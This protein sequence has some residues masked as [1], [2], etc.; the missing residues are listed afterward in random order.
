MASSAVERESRIASIASSA[1]PELSAST[2]SMVESLCSTV[3]ILTAVPVPITSCRASVVSSSTVPPDSSI[4]SVAFSQRLTRPTL[5]GSWMMQSK[6]VTPAAT[7]RSPAARPATPSG[8][9]KWVIAPNARPRSSPELIENTVIPAATAPRIESSIA[10]GSASDTT[11]TS[12]LWETALSTRRICSC[13][14]PLPSKRT[15]R[16]NSR[17]AA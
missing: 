17:W 13:T 2:P 5:L 10:S 15:S 7:S 16:P 14:S 9:P 4:A 12:N 1:T 3:W 8:W 11:I 6:R